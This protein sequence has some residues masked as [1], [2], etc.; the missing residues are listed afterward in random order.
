[1]PF[2]VLGAG[3]TRPCRLRR[4]RA[5]QVMDQLRRAT[6]RPMVHDLRAMLDAIGHVT[7]QGV[8]WRALPTDFPP[9]EGVYAFYQ[10]WSERQPSQL[11]V[12]RL[13]ARLRGG[14]GPDVQPSAA[15]IDSRSV[16]AADA[17]TR[18]SDSGKKINGRE[19]HIAVETEGL[20]LAA[21]ARVR[22]QIVTRTEA[23]AFEVLPAVGSWNAASPG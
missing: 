10:R 8:E 5:R 1:M 21:V 15:I 7:R 11:L 18:G 22:M 19:R 14:V 12:D 16:K 2:T 9:W 13:R 6:G 20:L 4:D 23:H 17:A 3:A